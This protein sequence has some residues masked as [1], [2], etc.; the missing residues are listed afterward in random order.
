VT[1][2]LRA[3]GVRYL[4][5]RPL[6]HGMDR[7]DGVRLELGLPGEVARRLAE[8]EGDVALMPLAAAAALGEMEIVPDVAI[9]C[10]GA[11][12]SV[13]I[14]GERP[15]HELDEIAL[16]LSSRT[17]VVLTRLLLARG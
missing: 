10:R 16:D 9:A 5:A 14:V 15:L 12:R 13:V 2:P 4:N 8:D 6:Y 17:S 3:L 7:D 11:V 1:A